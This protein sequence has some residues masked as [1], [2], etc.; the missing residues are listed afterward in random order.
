MPIPF[1]V[2]TTTP[3]E[4]QKQQL[5]R[6]FVALMVS[7]GLTAKPLRPSV[8]MG[9]YGL[10]LHNKILYFWSWNAC[11]VRVGVAHGITKEA[12]T[13]VLLQAGM[14]KLSYVFHVVFFPNLLF[15]ADNMSSLA[16]NTGMPHGWYDAPYTLNLHKNA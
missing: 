2:Q 15:Q 14:S 10:L 7:L 9:L 16:F 6:G 8:T 11:N 12:P 13:L 5:R 4:K 3:V 1:S